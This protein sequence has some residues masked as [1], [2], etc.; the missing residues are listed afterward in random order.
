MACGQKISFPSLSS[1]KG[2]AALLITG[3]ITLILIAGT[4]GINGVIYYEHKSYV[5]E[6]A[7][8]VAGYGA[9][10]LPNPYDA[11][12][13]SLKYWSS[14]KPL[15][16]PLGSD[17]K[18]YMYITSA[19]GDAV[20][21][22]GNAPVND[23][24]SNIPNQIFDGILA[25]LPVK[26]ITIKVESNPPLALLGTFLG[27]SSP[28]VT[29]E[30]TSHLVPTDIVLVVEN[31]NSLISTMNKEDDL[32]G[33]LAGTA[34]GQS[35]GWD[36]WT[37]RNL[38]RKCSGSS[39]VTGCNRKLCAPKYLRYARQCFGRV[40]YDIKRGALT[41]YDLLSSSGT[42]RVAVVHNSTAGAEQA[43]VAVPF[44]IHPT[45]V[46]PNNSLATNLTNKNYPYYGINV[47]PHLDSTGS[48]EGDAEPT[49]LE[50]VY[51]LSDHPSTRCAR[52][53]EVTHDA[54]VIF[55][56]PQHPYSNI[57]NYSGSGL[58]SVPRIAS[59]YSYYG[60]AMPISPS[61]TDPLDPFKHLRFKTK[62]A[63][64]Y[65]AGSELAAGGIGTSAE[66]RLLPRDIIWMKNS[67]YTYDSGLPI[68][69][70][71][72][73]S[74]QFGI[75]RAI[76]LLYNAPARPDGLPV[77][78]R[79]ILTLTDGFDILVGDTD[80]TTIES[81]YSPGMKLKSEFLEPRVTISN[82][83]PGLSPPLVGTLLSSDTNSNMC[84]NLSP[85]GPTLPSW[86]PFL[87]EHS[88]N[89]PDDVQPSSVS[90]LDQKAIHQG[91]KL[92]ILRYGFGGENYIDTDDTFQK[93][94]VF[95]NDS[96]ANI[97][98][99]RCIQPNNLLQMWAMRRGRFWGE[100]ADNM[101]WQSTTAVDGYL[102]H[103]LNTPDG[104]YSTLAPMTARTI[105][106]P[107]V[108]Q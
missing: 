84:V 24:G 105:F 80:S 5:K 95:H 10:F 62:K 6:V 45:W 67:G 65:S 71:N 81:F 90:N 23:D 102:K 85:T 92:G 76:D 41:L 34:F 19:A 48:T 55:R 1:S 97:Q 77:R 96:A 20:S 93:N 64:R 14:I 22:T 101:Q 98:M 75:S 16:F 104:Y 26:S 52:L 56:T 36:M 32:I 57:L 50:E 3:M 4:V 99:R 46:T 54:S 47:D 108:V 63:G 87:L 13:Q 35:P 37:P 89:V 74:M 38:C 31:T 33:V 72:Y 58:S 91:F 66:I 2:Y 69:R 107:E 60:G 28:T 61:A 79:I 44:G 17:P 53:T 18:I 82:L 86:S 103:N 27:M 43:H 30:A 21:I 42:Y 51:G 106:A 83:T 7:K 8:S 59:I 15:K 40:A 88:T 94:L 25:A 29:A 39:W 70:H 49:R 11:T 78:R 100:S 9:T 73:T 12:T 68:P